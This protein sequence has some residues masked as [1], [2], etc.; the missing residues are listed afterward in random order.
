MDGQRGLESL[1][2][3]T[4][5]LDRAMWQTVLMTG[6]RRGE[7]PGLRRRACLLDRVT[8]GS[9]RP[10]SMFVGSGLVTAPRHAS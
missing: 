2:F 8:G 9:Q 1:D 10:R 3:T 6:M 5:D 4:R 7:V